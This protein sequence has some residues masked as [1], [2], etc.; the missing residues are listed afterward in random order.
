MQLYYPLVSF[1]DPAV[2][3][4]MTNALQRSSHRALLGAIPS[5]NLQALQ[6]HELMLVMQLLVRPRDTVGFIIAVEDSLPPPPAKTSVQL[7]E[8]TTTVNQC[9]KGFMDLKDI[10]TFARLNCGSDYCPTGLG[11]ATN[12]ND[13]DQYDRPRVVEFGALVKKVIHGH[14]AENLA[15][16]FKHNLSNPGV[17]PARPNFSGTAKPRT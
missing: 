7:A 15:S 4:A 1:I 9:V 12:P 5:K 10:V 17:I 3:S 14:V 2:I 8:I 16:Y 13:R 11:F 6:N